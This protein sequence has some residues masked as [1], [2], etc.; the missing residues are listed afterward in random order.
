MK[1]FIIKTTGVVLC[2][3]TIIWILPSKREAGVKAEGIP[4]PKIRTPRD[5]GG[6]RVRD[7]RTREQNLHRL[8]LLSGAGDTWNQYSDLRPELIATLRELCDRGDFAGAVS[9]ASNQGVDARRLL[10][11]V[12]YQWAKQD[13]DESLAW[14]RSSS[15]SDEDKQAGLE[16]ILGNA[17]EDSSVE[18]IAWVKDMLQQTRA[19]SGFDKRLDQ[20]AR[21]WI[22]TGAI[23]AGE[24]VSWWRQFS[25]E[26]STSLDPNGVFSSLSGVAFCLNSLYQPAEVAAQMK[27]PSDATTSA[28][29]AT[30]GGDLLAAMNELSKSIRLDGKEEWESRLQGLA[31]TLGQ[32]AAIQNELNVPLDAYISPDRTELQSEY[33]RGVGFK[34]SKF[35]AVEVSQLAAASH[36]SETVNALWG[37]F[38]ELKYSDQGAG[39]LIHQIGAPEVP[40]ALKRDAA[41]RIADQMIKSDSLGASKEIAAQ[42]EGVIR[43]A[44]IGMLVKYLME[45]DQPEEAK[46]WQVGSP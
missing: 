14:L 42:P 40:D 11:A 27:H 18:G 3:L 29:L 46:Q 2:M 32:F 20:I 19:I 6:A 9:L 7:Q 21:G 28:E 13:R 22:V 24:Y 41:I 35:Q 10:S 33:F 31:T 44:M 8:Q 45:H 37:G 12:F 5:V 4:A 43:T 16:G 25:S 17:S 26:D 30:L 38:I 39:E 23:S 34:L 36:N 1:P 15:L